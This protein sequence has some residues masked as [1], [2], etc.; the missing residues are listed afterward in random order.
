MKEMSNSNRFILP[1]S[2]FILPKTVGPL[3]RIDYLG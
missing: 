1:P 3:P 2:S